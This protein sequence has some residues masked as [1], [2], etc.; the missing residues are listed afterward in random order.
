M[1]FTQHFWK[2]IYTRKENSMLNT[3]LHA[4]C[5]LLLTYLLYEFLAILQNILLKENYFWKQQWLHFWKQG[6][7]YLFIFNTHIL[8]RK[9]VLWYFCTSEMSENI[10]S[11]TFLVKNKKDS[12]FSIEFGKNPLST[13]LFH[14]F[15]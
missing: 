14:L 12:F 4:L 1:S 15:W 5:K 10:R 11:S 7:K 8:T 6:N 3:L 9:V 13:Y 2:K